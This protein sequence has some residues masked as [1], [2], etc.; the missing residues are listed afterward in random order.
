MSPEARKAKALIKSREGCESLFGDM[1][2][3]GVYLTAVV[4]S[5]KLCYDFPN[6]VEWLVEKRGKTD[7]GKER[8]PMN[9]PKVR[10]FVRDLRERII[11]V[12]SWRRFRIMLPLTY[13]RVR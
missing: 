12:M 9:K 1:K 3:I 11:E 4:T 7:Y 8:K 5:N 2:G 6:M 10:D 13:I